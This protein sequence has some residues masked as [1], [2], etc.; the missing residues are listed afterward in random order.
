[1]A[2]TRAL[3]VQHS[4]LA[5]TLAANASLV[6]VPART[7][8]SALMHVC[9]YL[10]VATSLYTPIVLARIIKIR[11]VVV[12]HVEFEIPGYRVVR[13]VYKTIYIADMNKAQRVNFFV[14]FG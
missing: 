14:S 2:G 13:C 11:S 7:P 8:V 5:E 6:H 9:T 10:H 3:G 4:Q 12:H 1:M